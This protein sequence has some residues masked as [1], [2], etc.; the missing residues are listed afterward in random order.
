M[1]KR[2]NLLTIALAGASIIAAAIMFG[3][4]FEVGRVGAD[5]GIQVAEQKGIIPKEYNARTVFVS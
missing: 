2:N 5:R 3:V 1:A 4:G